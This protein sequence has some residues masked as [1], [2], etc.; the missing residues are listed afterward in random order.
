MDVVRSALGR[1]AQ[2][3]VEM[4]ADG[5]FARRVLRL[6]F[7]SAVALGVL[8]ALARDVEGAPPLVGY[9][10]VGGWILM[11]AVLFGSLWR[12]RLRYALVVPATLATLA[13][14]AL[15]ATVV[16]RGAG[17]ATG[18]LLITA[19][20][21]LGGTMG[22]WFWFRL[23]PVPAPLHD[24]FSPGRWTLVAIHVLLVV[25]GLLAVGARTLSALGMPT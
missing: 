22:L 9:F 18:W 17:A 20:V 11:P 7:T 12:P 2:P 6:A 13:L 25:S 3:A 5:A 16:P 24:P 21:L 4:T 15:C 10:L 8:W 14:V 23:L 19:G 1:D